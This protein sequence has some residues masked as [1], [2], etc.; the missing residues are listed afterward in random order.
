[1]LINVP[2]TLIFTLDDV[3]LINDD[4]YCIPWKLLDEV[5]PVTDIFTI[6]NI[7][8]T[9]ILFITMVIFWCCSSF[10]NLIKGKE[11]NIKLATYGQLGSVQ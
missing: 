7:I 3:S 1:M 2:R 5:S 8:I 10:F 4:N 6:I 9:I 11:I